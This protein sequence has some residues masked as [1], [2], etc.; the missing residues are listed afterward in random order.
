[1]IKKKIREFLRY[2]SFEK[3]YSLNTIKSYH[4]DLIEFILYLEKIGV[5]SLSA[6]ESHHLRSYLLFLKTQKKSL[7]TVARKISSIRSFLKFL[8]KNKKISCNLFFY[9]SIP[10]LSKKIPLVPTEEEIE[11]FILSLEKEEKFLKIRDRALFEIAYGCGLRVSEIANLTLDQINLSSQIIRVLGKGKKER[12]VPFGKK[13]LEVLENYLKLREA[14]LYKLKK[15]TNYVFLNF[16]GEKLTERGIRYITK[17]QAKKRGL[18]Y[19]HPHTLRHAFA[20]HLLNAG[21]DLRS[22]QEMLGHSSL[23]TTEIYT[24]VN[25]EYLLKTYL[26]AHPRAKE[27]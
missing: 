1:M 18:I 8:S 25:Y 10:K 16:K 23:I 7:P 27:K 21:A 19:L 15:N 22:I 26:K 13:A 17:K 2:L 20:T 14:F 12:I 4:K 6:L 9:L 5:K 11:S 24:K 3:N